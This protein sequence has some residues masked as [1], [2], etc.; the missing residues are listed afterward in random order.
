[1]PKSYLENKTGERMLEPQTEVMGAPEITLRM[2]SEQAHMLHLP[3]I[4]TGR[5][6]G[7]QTQQATIQRCDDATI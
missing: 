6:G 1:M 5:V 7:Q 3:M 4:T 2:G